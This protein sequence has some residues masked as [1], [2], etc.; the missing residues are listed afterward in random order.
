MEAEISGAVSRKRAIATLNKSN[1]TLGN[2]EIRKALFAS[3]GTLILISAVLIL[4]LDG[5]SSLSK[6][7]HFHIIHMLQGAGTGLLF[8]LLQAAAEQWLPNHWINDGGINK[9]LIQAFRLPELI[10]VMLGVAWIEETLFRGILQSLIGF[11]A[12]NTI[13]ALIHFRYLKRPVLLVFIIGASFILGGLR[14][15][16]GGLIAPIL[17]HFFINSLP[18]LLEKMN[19]NKST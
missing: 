9:Q 10:V 8:V 17:A 11:W 5:T 6:W 7:Y 19:N 2:P 4:V 15:V 16:S 1:R 12:A 3:Q 13:F 14:E 18:V